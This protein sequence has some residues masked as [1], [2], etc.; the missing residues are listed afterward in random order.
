MTLKLSRATWAILLLWAAI[1]ALDL[2]KAFHIDDT[3]HLL[4]AQWVGQHPLQPMSGLVNWGQNPEPL[5]HFNQPP[6]FFYLVAATGYAFGWGEVPMHLMRSL[7]TLL[8]LVCFHR[9]A[10][11]TAPG[12]ELWLTALFALCPAFMVNQGLMTDIP[13]LALQLLFFYLLLVPGRMNT[14]LRL[15]LAALALAAAMFIKYTTLPLLLVFPLALLLR[16]QWQ[17]LPLALVPVVLITAWSGWNLHEYGGVHLLDRQGGDPS[18]VGI[19][20]RTL[21]LLTCIGAVSPF[22]PALLRPLLPRPAKHL[23][24]A[25]LMLLGAAACLIVLVYIGTIPEIV[26]DQVLRI[27]FTL[28]GVLIVAICARFLPLNKPSIAADKWTLVLWALGLA[29]FLALFSPMMAS[30]HILLVL[31]PVLLLT[32]PALAKATKHEKTLALACTAFLGVV[33]TL[34]DK[35]YADFYRERAPRIAQELSGHGSTVW[36]LGHWGWQWYSVEA[37]M[38]TYSKDA[39]KLAVGDFLV[40]PEDYDHQELATGVEK[41]PVATWDQ[42]PSLKNFFCV[43][44]FAGMYSSGYSKLPWSLCRSHHKIITAYRVT[45]VR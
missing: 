10:R 42:A 39:G 23:L 41:V 6:G 45:S 40:I 14:G 34:S 18:I 29:S 27:A 28:N 13:L 9:L 8:A 37:G 35:Q 17:W 7:F 12:Q 25:W 30:R 11:R 38:K 26:S 36:S 16:R 5:H 15:A 31:P 21:A 1:T 20:V 2:N 19:F 24:S 22:T 33:L 32:A 43:E 3:F 4:A 44:Q